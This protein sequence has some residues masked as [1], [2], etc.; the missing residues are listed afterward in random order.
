MPSQ[1]LL[2]AFL[3]AQREH[4]RPE[5]A[6]L[7]DRGRRRVSG[8]RR[9]ELAML[10]DVSPDYYIRLEQG[11]Q[12]PSERVTQA[13][14]R[15]LQ[16]DD[17]A[18]AYLYELTRPGL[19]TRGSRRSPESAARELQTL[20]DQWT[21]TPAWVSDRCADVIAANALATELNP[22]YKPGCNSLRDQLLQETAKREIFINYDECIAD[23]VASLRARAG[24]HLHDPRIS[25]YIDQLTRESPLFARLWARQE[26]RF[27]AAGYKRLHHPAVGRLDFRSESMTVNDTDGYIM[28]LYYAEPGS[29]TATKVCELAALVQSRQ[30]QSLISTE[31]QRTSL[32]PT[33][34]QRHDNQQNAHLALT[35][36]HT[37][38]GRRGYRRR[39]A[40]HGVPRSSA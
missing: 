40:S 32:R 3:R 34:E 35:A 1:N 8:L 6:G 11:R 25:S 39:E 33:P 13:L 37:L 5:D 28:T 4:M 27:H 36:K 22:S 9:E 17:I 12:L 19:E 24:A 23:A 20:L 26:V 29:L 7:A 14:A 15:A 16:L 2:G 18:T 31:K 30:A 21:T 38:I 10:A